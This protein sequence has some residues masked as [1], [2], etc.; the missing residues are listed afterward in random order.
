MKKYLLIG[1]ALLIGVIGCSIKETEDEITG[2][3]TL[4]FQAVPFMD[5]DA[6]ED[7]KTAVIPDA[8]YSS[9]G[10]IWS[11]KDTV[12]IFPDAGSQIYFTMASGAGASS[13]QFD[14]GAWT[15]KD[16]YEYWSYFPFIGNYYLNPAKIP[17]TF[18]GQKQ[19]GNANSDHFQKYDYMYAPMTRKEDNFL[20]FSYQHL[21]TGVLPWVDLPAGHYTGLTLSLEEALFVTKGE[22]NLTSTSPA[23]S[24]KEYS[25]SLHI[26]LDITLTDPGTLI[27]YVPMAPID[28]RGKTLTITVSD[29]GAR[30]FE[31]TYNP[32]K[33]YVASNIYRLRSAKSFVNGTVSL[34][35]TEL[36]LYVGQS[37]QLTATVLPE[38]AADKSVAWTSS[39]TDVAT[40]DASGKV[41]AVAV[42][43][44]TITATAT[45]GGNTATCAVTVSPV[46][47]TSVELNKTELA[48]VKGASETLT[49]TVLPENATDKSVTWASSDVTVVTVS[50]GVVTAKKNGT[51]T[52]TATAG[53]KSATCVITVSDGI[54]EIVDETN[55]EW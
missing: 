25:N 23:I 10:F 33:A 18:L 22:Y 9:Y 20:N 36:P 42:G 49:A 6:P 24:G 35:K 16:G 30:S 14:G 29:E 55:G 46:E 8:S 50:N 27:V 39:N 17:V 47:V 32:G 1:L 12:G 15:C 45:Q 11:A 44:A 3:L 34:D 28:M 41:T 43:S 52:I 40:V 13:A 54:T 31:Y 38:N 53:G 21:I 7:T 51:A 26:D 4:V 5:G 2:P 19:V 37:Q 48:L